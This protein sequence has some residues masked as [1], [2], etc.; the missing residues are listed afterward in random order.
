MTRAPGRA[1]RRSASDRRPATY[2]ERRALG[3]SGLEVSVVGMGTWRTLDVRGVEQEERATR[4]VEAAFEAGTD[5]F[6]S[7]PMYGEAER[8]L[9]QALGD[10]RDK[11]LVATKVW[12]SSAREARVQYERSLR[13]FG[14][15]VDLWQVHN[16]VGWPERLTELEQLRSQGRA[17]ALGATHYLASQFGELA[18]VMRSG[19]IDAVQVPYN[20]LEREVEKQI[21][22]LAEELGLGVVVMRPLGGGR[23]ARRTPGPEDLR[24]LEDLG[25]R[26]WG[27]ALLKWVLSDERCQVA[28]PAT[29]RPER[30]AENAA[31]GEPPWLGPEERRLVA[32]LAGAA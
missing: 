32:D 13:L 10:R 3:R 25:I 21:L 29:S 12:T 5:F 26:T 1:S 4:V 6:D 22:P 31:A 20:P 2:V 17:R 9:G 30:A 27:Q 11:A 24:P 18:E 16:L 14:G 23:L 19:R 15:W 7:S 28:I 8:V